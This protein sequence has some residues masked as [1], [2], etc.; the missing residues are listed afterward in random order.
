MNKIAFFILC[1]LLGSS[2]TA[3]SQ[4]SKERVLIGIP[5]YVD[6]HS[7]LPEA[8]ACLHI[9]RKERTDNNI[10]DDGNGYVDDTY[11]IAFNDYYWLIP[12][13]SNKKGI[14]YSYGVKNTSHGAYVANTLVTVNPNVRLVFAEIPLYEYILDQYELR[15]LLRQQPQK[16]ANLFCDAF[17]RSVHYMDSLGVKIIPIAWIWNLSFF[18]RFF[19]NS[20]S[21]NCYVEWLKV[22]RA[23]M[24]KIIAG[25][26]HILFLMAAG[27][28]SQDTRR[29][30]T[31][32][33]MIKYPNALTVGARDRNCQNRAYFSNYGPLVDV[34]AAGYIT[35]DFSSKSRWLD[36]EEFWGTSA[37]TPIAAAWAAYWFSQGLS[38]EEVVRRL[39]AADCLPP[40]IP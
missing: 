24:D 18:K 36:K 38:M 22:F 9:N 20:I 4:K 10:D 15:T 16:A 7:L 2:F 32:H 23:R 14:E 19:G 6:P 27:N 12:F 13:V 26:P 28:D 29:N 5:E 37:A 35:L 30:L 11:G 34:W 21:E 40:H 31:M 8:Q 39:K 33:S 3:S 1:L 25:H 17:E